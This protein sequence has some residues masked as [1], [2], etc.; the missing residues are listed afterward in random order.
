[1]HC[2]VAYKKSPRQIAQERAVADLL[3]HPNTPLLGLFRAS[4]GIRRGNRAIWPIPR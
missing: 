2:L 3:A 1:M 4:A